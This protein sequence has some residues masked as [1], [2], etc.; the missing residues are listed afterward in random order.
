MPSFVCAS[1]RKKR[2][3]RLPV[4][5]TFSWGVLEGGVGDSMGAFAVPYSSA[6]LS[7]ALADL[8]WA[9][10]GERLRVP[11]SSLSLGCP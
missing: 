8:L 2:L 7:C 1:P 9:F 5:A 4:V 3:P 10:L 11:G 6:A